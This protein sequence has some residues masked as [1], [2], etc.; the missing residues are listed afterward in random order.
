[1]SE[2]T[3]KFCKEKMPIMALHISNEVAMQNGYCCFFCMRS[4]LGDVAYQMVG[5]KEENEGK[6]K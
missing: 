6:G 4:A 5:K 1:M 2:G 3:C